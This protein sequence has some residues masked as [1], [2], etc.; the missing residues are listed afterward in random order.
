MRGQCIMQ[1]W[2]LSCYI[3]LPPLVWTHFVRAPSGL[4]VWWVL[5]V[6]MLACVLAL[7][8]VLVHANAFT[9]TRDQMTMC[10]YA[11]PRDTRGT[12]AGQ[13]RGAT[14]GTTS[15]QHTG[16]PPGQPWDNPRDS[17]GTTQMATKRKGLGACRHLAQATSSAE[18]G[19]NRRVLRLRPTPRSLRMYA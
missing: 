10:A 9:E 6:S 11:E 8:R 3:V 13:P 17:H 16:Q 7:T 1:L 12:T 19:F 4:D 14:Q 15:G 2:L 18:T 5:G